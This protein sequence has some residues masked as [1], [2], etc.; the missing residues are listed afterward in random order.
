MPRWW[1]GIGLAISWT[2]IFLT[3]INDTDFWY[4][5]FNSDLRFLLIAPQWLA[6]YMFSGKATNPR[7]A[8]SALSTVIFFA[9]LFALDSYYNVVLNIRGQNSAPMAIIVLL[10][11][12]NFFSLLAMARYGKRYNHQRKQSRAEKALEQ[13]EL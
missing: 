3:S 10:F 4:S 2:L 7:W 8:Y 13:A 1:F 6:I 12:V 11:L 9:S 5:A